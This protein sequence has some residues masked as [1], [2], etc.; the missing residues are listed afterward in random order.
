MSMDRCMVC[1]DLIDT[2]SHPEAYREEFENACLCEECYELR[3]QRE[4]PPEVDT[5]TGSLF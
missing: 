3:L 4:M 2:D 1:S 5:Q